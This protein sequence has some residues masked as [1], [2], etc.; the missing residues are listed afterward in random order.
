M[1]KPYGIVHYSLAHAII[2]NVGV[3]CIVGILELVAFMTY[4]TKYGFHGKTKTL[5]KLNV[6]SRDLKMA[7]LSLQQGPTLKINSQNFGTHE[8]L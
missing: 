8:N 2:T 5:V 3:W 7:T 4:P 6:F 1:Q